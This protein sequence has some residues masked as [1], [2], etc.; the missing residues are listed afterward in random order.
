MTLILFKCVPEVRQD[1][2]NISPASCL[3]NIIAGS[4]D[5]CRSQATSVNLGWPPAKWGFLVSVLTQIRWQISDAL[6]SNSYTERCA[7]PRSGQAPT[8]L[9]IHEQECWWQV[10]FREGGCHWQKGT[11]W[12]LNLPKKVTSTGWQ[13]KELMSGQATNWQRAAG[14]WLSWAR[15]FKSKEHSLSWD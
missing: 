2:I 10:T 6:F 3:L 8:L 11:V 12:K 15:H 13:E 9:C 5:N 4:S 14:Y 7:S 1:F